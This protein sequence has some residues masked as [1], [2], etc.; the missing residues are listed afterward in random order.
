MTSKL[1]VVALFLATTGTLNATEKYWIVHEARLIVVGTLHPYPIFPWFDGWHLD[2]T[3]EVEEVL[4]GTKPPRPIIYRCVFK[5]PKN[6]LSI[7]WRG[8]FDFSRETFY[9]EKGLWFL[10][11][12]DDRTWQPSVGIGFVDLPQRTDYESHIRR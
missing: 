10:R 8:L 2:G 4:F 9:K 6:P 12:N 5:Y 1:A 11:P 3:I 7:N